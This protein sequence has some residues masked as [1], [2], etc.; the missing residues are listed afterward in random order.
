MS[1]E[2]AK[3]IF[4]Q[5]IKKA[6]Y[7]EQEKQYQKDA[8]NLFILSQELCPLDYQVLRNLQP[9]EYGTKDEE[10]LVFQY[11]PQPEKIY[12]KVKIKIIINYLKE[13][14]WK[15]QKLSQNL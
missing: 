15:L 2:F 5:Q 4:D 14:K 12:Y 8:K 3:K 10:H 11:N 7:S 13:R 9:Y 1:I 6:W